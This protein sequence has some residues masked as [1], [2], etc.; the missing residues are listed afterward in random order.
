[1]QACGVIWWN[2]NE[3]WLHAMV[4]DLQRIKEYPAKDFQIA[5]DV[6][7]DVWKA[8]EFLVAAGY[9]NTLIKD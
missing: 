8:Y 9:T 6:P 4:G 5:Q 3:H 7:D 1:M 2:I